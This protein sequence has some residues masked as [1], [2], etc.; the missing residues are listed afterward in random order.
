MALVTLR[1]PAKGYLHSFPMLPLNNLVC[2][3]I[4]KGPIISHVIHMAL[5][6][7][8]PTTLVIVTVFH[9]NQLKLNVDR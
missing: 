3:Y 6:L 4:P 1:L 7:L 9:S 5:H 8:I 2:P